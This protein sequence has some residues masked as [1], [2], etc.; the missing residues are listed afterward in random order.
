[1]PDPTK[2]ELQQMLADMTTRATAAETRVA[3]LTSDLASANERADKEAEARKEAD[4]RSGQLEKDNR[5]LASSLRAYKGSAT[6]L[7]REATILK[8]EL[9]PQSRPI[10]AMKP[11]RD[12]EEAAVRQQALEA[13][14]ALG[15]T[16]IVFSDGKREIREIAPLV[17]DG[18]AWSVTPHHRELDADPIL[19]PVGERAEVE[20]RGFALLSD[21]GE[22]VGWCPLPTPITIGRAQR[23]RIPRGSIR[24]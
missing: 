19:E 12:D 4:Q 20:L 7:R 6:K 10:G 22:Q 13:A 23:M 17:C 14:F 24:F 8:G 2:P 9:S 3:T 5:E 11:A 1:M 18:N 16:T 21:A 15:P